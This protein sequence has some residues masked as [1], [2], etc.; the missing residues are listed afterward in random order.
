LLKRGHDIEVNPGIVLP[1]VVDQTT[2]VTL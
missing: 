1:A 2:T